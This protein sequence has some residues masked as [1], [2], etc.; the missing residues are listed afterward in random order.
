MAKYFTKSGCFIGCLTLFL[1]FILITAILIGALY[2]F[3]FLREKEPGS[4]FKVG[5]ST[6]KT[7]DCEDSFICLNDNLEKCAPAEGMADLGDFAEVALEILGISQGDSC[8]VYAK[9]IEVK[10]LP[11]GLDTIPNFI[12][13]KMFENLS[14]ECL[15]PKNVYQQGIEKA[16]EYIGDNIYEICRGPLFDFMDK[17]GIEVK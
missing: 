10:K 6:A 15:V 2:Y 8:V 9:V 12:V 1:L 16:G 17:F 13:E 11:P 5:S 14:M 3:L 4:Y 7:V